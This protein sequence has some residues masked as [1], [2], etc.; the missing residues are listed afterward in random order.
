[1]DISFQQLWLQQKDAIDLPVMAEA[2]AAVR[3]KAK[4]L[5]TTPEHDV[6][7]G[8][9]AAAETA[10]KKG[11]GPMMLEHLKNCGSWIKDAATDL[12]AKV[13]VEAMDR[14]AKGQQ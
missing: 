2:L 9:L 6:T 7:V 4:A 3:Q 5:A 13:I 11:D 10:A 1:H 12:G 14:L 8:E